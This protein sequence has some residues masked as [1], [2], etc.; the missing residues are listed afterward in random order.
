[1]DHVW[2]FAAGQFEEH[3]IGVGLPGHPIF[4]A[5]FDEIILQRQLGG[6]RE[7]EP[8]RVRWTMT[9]DGARR[10]NQAVPTAFR[11]S[12]LTPARWQARAAALLAIAP[13]IDGVETI[14]GRPSVIA[15]TRIPPD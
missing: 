6:V 1:M 3:L 14:G 15:R 5:P 2:P 10:W 7:R 13:D 12:D 9:G 4:H 11:E 8:L